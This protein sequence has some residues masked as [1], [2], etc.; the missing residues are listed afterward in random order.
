MIVRKKEPVDDL[1]SPMRLNNLSK[2][3]TML[4]I[5]S[6]ASSVPASQSRKMFGF[7]IQ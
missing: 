1:D 6:I 7:W 3:S 4:R 5:S 2:I